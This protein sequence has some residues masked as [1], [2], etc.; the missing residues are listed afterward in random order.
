MLL[1][2]YTA[3]YNYDPEIRDE[4]PENF[5]ALRHTVDAFIKSKEYKLVVRARK[6]YR[7]HM[8]DYIVHVDEL[9]CSIHSGYRHLQETMIDELG[10]NETWQSF[11]FDFLDSIRTGEVEPEELRDTILKHY[12]R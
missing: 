8:S 11:Y 4:H 9:G 1:F 6:D 12:P 2:A 7:E 10:T 3:V 5:E